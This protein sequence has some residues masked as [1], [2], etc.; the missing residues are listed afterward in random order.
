MRLDAELSRNA[1]AKVRLAARLVESEVHGD[2]GRQGG[3]GPGSLSR[4]AGGPKARGRET[5]LGVDIP[6]RPLGLP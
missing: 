1:F 6:D 4:R 2:L 3:H 5:G